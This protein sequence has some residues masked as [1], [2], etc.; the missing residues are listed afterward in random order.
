MKEI[1]KVKNSAPSDG[2]GP[3]PNLR[4]IAGRIRPDRETAAGF[5]VRVLR[6][7]IITGVMKGGEG[8][9]QDAIAEALSI[10]KVP[11]REALRDLE[12]Q[13]LIQFQSFRGYRVRP[14]VM[15]EMVEAFE[16]RRLLEGRAVTAS[17][18]LAT[19]ADLDE[20]EAMI[21]EFEA[22]PD[23]M[24]ASD[25]NLRLHLTLYRGA[26]MPML[27]GMITQA[28]TITQRY[29]HIHRR[30]T[31][32]ALDVQDEHREIL[33]AYRSRDI[34]ATRDLM[35]RHIARAAAY[36]TEGLGADQRW[37]QES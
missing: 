14:P 16:L 13:R 6:E 28:H 29:T 34:A 31:G 4:Y 26:Q 11:L 30:L 36:V 8:I 25:W 21:D 37:L 2:T 24:I 15:A 5:A 9:R 7:A 12:S 32:R 33:A 35:D 1:A 23:P 19:D 27:A 17:V 20:A 10:S 22:A 3:H 18:P